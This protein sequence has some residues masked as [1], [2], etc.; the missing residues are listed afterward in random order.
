M[1]S[2]RAV[3]LFDEFTELIRSFI[4]RREVTRTEYAA[5]MNYVISVGKA[6]EWPL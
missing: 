2:T 5:I 6:G 3:E 4:V 1:A